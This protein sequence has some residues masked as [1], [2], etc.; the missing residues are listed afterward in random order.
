MD[1]QPLSPDEKRALLAELLAKKSYEMFYPLSFSQEG[2]WFIEQ[3]GGSASAY[4]IHQAYTLEGP[5]DI[6]ALEKS[7]AALIERHEM[8]RT[9]F[10]VSEEGIPQ[11]QIMPAAPFSIEVVH[12]PSESELQAVV[13]SDFQRPFQLEA[14][15][16]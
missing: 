12:I 15:Y 6:V 8:L 7:F 11:Q 16:T 2:L 1:P 4:H 9:R 13:A 10:M 14:G 5:L 3:L